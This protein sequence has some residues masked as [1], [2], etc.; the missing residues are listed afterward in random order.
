MWNQHVI[1][2]MYIWNTFVLFYLILF[3]NLVPYL[4]THMKTYMLHITTCQYKPIRSGFKQY[5]PTLLLNKYWLN[6]DN[7]CVSFKFIFKYWVKHYEILKIANWGRS[8]LGRP[9]CWGIISQQVNR[10]KNP[11]YLVNKIEILNEWFENEWCGE[12]EII[13]ILNIPS[14]S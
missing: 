6:P 11:W 3:W 9:I 1:H 5:L 4:K 14:F 12:F 8:E 2:A 13:Q 7:I 10:K